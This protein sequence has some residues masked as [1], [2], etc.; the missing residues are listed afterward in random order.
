MADKL[1]RFRTYGQQARREYDRREYHRKAEVR[2]VRLEA[3]YT[4]TT[5]P[6]AVDVR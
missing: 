3:I 5:A 2:A 6:V 1:K 4:K